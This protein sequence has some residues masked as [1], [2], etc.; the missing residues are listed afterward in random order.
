MEGYVARG[1]RA[2]NALAADRGTGTLL[3]EEPKLATE[4][5]PLSPAQHAALGNI[6][7]GVKACLPAP[8]PAITY[9]DGAL[10]ELLR[11]RDVYDATES[12]SM[13]PYD[14]EKLKVLRGA[15]RPLDAKAL[16]GDEA[17]RYLEMADELIVL[18]AEE[19]AVLEAGPKPHWD[20][21]LRFGGAARTNFVRRLDDVG[22]VA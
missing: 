5:D 18:P 1:V 16:V 8:D 19:L 21:T 15:T 20:A 12:L 6:A 4:A 17:R 3:V 22:L 7:R 9:P 2:L 10:C 14:A 13:A 11:S